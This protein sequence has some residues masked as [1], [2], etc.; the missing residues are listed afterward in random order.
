[1]VTSKSVWPEPVMLISTVSFDD[2][3]PASVTFSSRAYCPGNKFESLGTGDLE[4]DIVSEGP[5]IFIQR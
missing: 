2:K 4:S 5:E 1:M 3:P